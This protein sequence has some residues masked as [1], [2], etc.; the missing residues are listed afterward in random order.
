MAGLI[1]IQLLIP[2]AFYL[3]HPE[4]TLLTQLVHT[5]C[6]ASRADLDVAPMTEHNAL[7]IWHG[8]RACV[9]HKLLLC[10]PLALHS[11]DPVVPLSAV[12][13]QHRTVSIHKDS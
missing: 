9:H 1:S 3:G 11:T 7:L 12:Y 4:D 8:G 2:D 10:K 6:D 5:A 13:V